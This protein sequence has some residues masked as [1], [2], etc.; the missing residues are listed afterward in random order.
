M[1]MNWHIVESNWKLYVG[2]VKIQWEKLTDDHITAIAGKRDTLCGKI[3]EAYGISTDE[4]ENQIK[5]FESLYK[6]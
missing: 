2:S 6:I 1:A 3:Q 5:D 4:A